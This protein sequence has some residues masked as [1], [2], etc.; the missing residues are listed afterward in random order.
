MVDKGS[1]TA[2]ERELVLTLVTGW[3]WHLIPMGNNVLRDPCTCRDVQ[4]P[5]AKAQ[6]SMESPGELPWSSSQAL[7]STIPGYPL[8]ASWT[9]FRQFR[10]GLRAR[11]NGQQSLV[12]TWAPSSSGPLCFVSFSSFSFSLLDAIPSPLPMTHFSSFFLAFCLLVRS[13][14]NFLPHSGMR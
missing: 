11:K 13:L 10:A 14:Q 5:S 8:P 3:P 2:Q 1:C 9:H 12:C 6:D 4:C 7:C